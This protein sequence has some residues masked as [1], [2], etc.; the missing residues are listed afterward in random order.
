MPR[1]FP[2]AP[3]LLVVCCLL[4]LPAVPALGQ[5]ESKPEPP[6]LGDPG[7]IMSISVETGRMQEGVFTLAGRDASQQLLVTGDYDSG[8]Q[9]DLTGQVSYSASPEGVVAVDKTGHVTPVAEGAPLI[10]I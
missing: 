9:R 7:Q 8:Q 4:A 3:A 2:A 1:S 10:H 5:D 6:G